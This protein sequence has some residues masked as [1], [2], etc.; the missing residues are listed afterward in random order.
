MQKSLY[1][2][3]YR[4]FLEKLLQAR[5]AA[6]LTQ[7][8][9]ALKLKKPQSFISKIESGERRLDII[10]VKYLAKIYKKSLSYFVN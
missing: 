5:K 9:V 3:E 1:S 2:Q 4:K 6:G 7:K 8:E 10:E